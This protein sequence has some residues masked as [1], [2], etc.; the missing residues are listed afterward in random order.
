MQTFIRIVGYEAEGAEIANKLHSNLE[1][2]NLEQI[3][4]MTF[5]SA[6]ERGGINKCFR[7]DSQ[8]KAERKLILL[9]VHITGIVA[10]SIIPVFHRCAQRTGWELGVIM[11][12][13]EKHVDNGLP[14]SLELPE[15]LCDFFAVFTGENQNDEAYTSALSL[16]R[17]LRETP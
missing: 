8:Q 5:A 15:G 4:F 16:I 13:P 2:E 11:L 10:S 9:I 3:D 7:Q 14:Q 1:K 12:R 17:N 6:E